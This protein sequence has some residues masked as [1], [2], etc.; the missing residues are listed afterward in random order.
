ATPPA[1]A[2]SCRRRSG[3]ARPTARR[4]ARSSR[5]RRAAPP[6]RRRRRRPRGRPRGGG[7]DRAARR[8]TLGTDA[9]PPEAGRGGIAFRPPRAAPRYGDAVRIGILGGTGPAGRALA[10]RLASVGFDV[11]VGSRSKYR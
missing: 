11:V 2:S 1:A 4:A 5:A 10:A 3:R 7:R 8:A 9:G 6:A